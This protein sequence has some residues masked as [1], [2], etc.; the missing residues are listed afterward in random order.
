MLVVGAVDK[1]ISAFSPCIL[2]V[3]DVD[4]YVYNYVENMWMK[5]GKLFLN[6]WLKTYPQFV[7]TLSTTYPQSYQQ[8]KL[9]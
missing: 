5:C 8:I 3:F 2:R 7:H 9:D 4:N 6:F 1:L